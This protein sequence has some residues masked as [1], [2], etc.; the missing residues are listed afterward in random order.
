M[1]S[2]PPLISV[3][4]PVY[5]EEKTVGQLLNDLMKMM[6]R[7]PSMEII[8]VDDGS[9]DNTQ[10]EVER[11]PKVRYIRNGIN[12]GK[13]ATLARGLRAVSG[14]IVVV[15]D[16]DLEYPVSNIPALVK[17]TSSGHASV[18]YGSRFT[19]NRDGMSLS[20]FV[21]NMMLSLVTS[22]LLRKNLTDV[23]TGHKAFSTEVLNS[24][25]LTENGFVVEVEMTVKTFKAGWNIV[26]VPIFYSR[27][28]FGQAKI[29]YKDGLR[30]LIWLIRNAF[31][32]D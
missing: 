22:L 3:L 31:T 12:M 30:V 11:F 19:G 17:P 9:T 10:K 32:R 7:M 28:K 25:E 14:K 5:N 18:A 13:G 6:L 1:T 24:F 23:M 16:A 4:V 26:E 21:G 15:Q 8:V 27:R 20:H 2:Y 29:R